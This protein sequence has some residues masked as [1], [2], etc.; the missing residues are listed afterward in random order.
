LDLPSVS[1]SIRLLVDTPQ[2]HAGLVAGAIATIAVIAIARATPRRLPLAGCS[3][4]AATLIGLWH[5]G[6]VAAHQPLPV[7]V[8]VG[9]V[10]AFVLVEIAARVD[11]PPPL[12][13][14]AAMPGAL[15]TAGAL[16]GDPGWIRIVV[17][18]S[19]AVGTACVADVDAAD[20]ATLGPALWC[21]TVAGVYWT[22]PD[23]EAA[24]VAV[25]AA[26]PLVASGWPGRFARIGAGGAAASVCVLAWIVGEGGRGRP[27]AV[28]G[29]VASLGIFLYEPIVR[30]VGRR[31]IAVSGDPLTVAFIVVVQLAC[32]GAASRWAGLAEEAR[33][34]TLRALAFVPIAVGLTYAIDAIAARPARRGPPERQ[35]R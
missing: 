29:G 2:F 33:T 19:A 7:T 28:V 9:A 27:G 23:T 30:R 15:V 6:N 25:G 20:T 21:V 4:A 8:V 1:D 5:S 14:L 32:V 11:A 13:A 22:V 3:F 31:G 35:P 10:V 34:A 16:V 12:I 26:L 17:A 18:V 24:R